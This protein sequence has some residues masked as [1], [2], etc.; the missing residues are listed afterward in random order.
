M[1]KMTGLWLAQLV[2]IIYQW[3]ENF[4][5]RGANVHTDNGY[6][7]LLAGVD[8]YLDI[9]QELLNWGADINVLSPELQSQLSEHHITLP[10]VISP[11]E[12][13]QLEP[14]LRDSGNIREFGDRYILFVESGAYFLPK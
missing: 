7:L 6:P 3:F 1:F 2:I 14:T 4:L 12:Y 10:K 9:I 13:Y 11:E 5:N 8:G